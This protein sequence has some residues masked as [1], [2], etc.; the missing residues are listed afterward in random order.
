MSKVGE[1]IGENQIILKNKA[2]ESVKNHP[3]HIASSQ[4]DVSINKDLNTLLSSSSQKDLDIE[5][6]SQPGA[7]NIGGSHKLNL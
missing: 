1:G 4:K 5:K 6:S 7:Q 3:S 2:G